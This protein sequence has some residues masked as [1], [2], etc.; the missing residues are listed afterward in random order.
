MDDYGFGPKLTT[1]YAEN[2]L[3]PGSFVIFGYNQELWF[4]LNI[5]GWPYFLEGILN[6]HFKE[7]LEEFFALD[8]MIG[9]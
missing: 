6:I 4:Y 1:Y 8:T 5:H 2:S 3:S 7:K 9:I